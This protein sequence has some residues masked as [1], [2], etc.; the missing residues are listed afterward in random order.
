MNKKELRELLLKYN[1][2]YIVIVNEHDGNGGN[3]PTAVL[4]NK[5]FKLDNFDYIEFE[6][7]A[8]QALAAKSTLFEEYVQPRYESSWSKYHS[9]G[10]LIKEALLKQGN[11]T[12][13][14]Y[15]LKSMK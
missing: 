14:Y 6:G 15:Q 8:S 13:S 9:L 4:N 10:E 11:F 1:I 12:K 2:K 5:N 7:D 3:F